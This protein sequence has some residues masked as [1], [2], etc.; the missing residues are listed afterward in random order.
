EL[1]VPEASK[2]NGTTSKS[3]HSSPA[4]AVSPSLPDG[5]D[6]PYTQLIESLRNRNKELFSQVTAVCLRNFL[7][8]AHLRSLCPITLHPPA[9]SSLLPPPFL[10]RLINE[11]SDPTLRLDLAP[12]LNW[13]NRRAV[14]TA[15]QQGQLDVEP[16]QSTALI[17]ELSGP[18]GF[19]STADVLCA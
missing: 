9:L 1:T 16:S 2:V 10:T 13:L 18:M 4:S 19:L 6:D 15:I 14:Q 8:F 17:A 5:A 7:A 3:S 12:S 11:Y